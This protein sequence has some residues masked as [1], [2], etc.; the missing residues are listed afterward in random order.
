M[1]TLQNKYGEQGFLTMVYAKTLPGN[2]L[3]Q[4]NNLFVKLSQRPLF[5]IGYEKNIEYK[6]KETMPH[7]VG[8]LLGFHHTAPEAAKTDAVY[9]YFFGTNNVSCSQLLGNKIYYYT[10]VN[11]TQ[12]TALSYNYKDTQGQSWGYYN[13]LMFSITR[14]GEN[15]NRQLWTPGYQVSSSQILECYYQQ[16]LDF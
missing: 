6:T 5:L 9:E 10:H 15:I 3:G 14:N 16:A 1:V 8:H 4:A 12:Q 13:H 7:E 2:L 11:N